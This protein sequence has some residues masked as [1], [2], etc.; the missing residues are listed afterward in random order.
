[1]KMI[2]ILTASQHFIGEKMKNKLVCWIEMSIR[3]I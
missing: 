1:M 3:K 2:V